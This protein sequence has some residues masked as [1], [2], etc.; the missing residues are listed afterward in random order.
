MRKTVKNQI[1]KKPLFALALIA[2]GIGIAIYTNVGGFKEGNTTMSAKAT[3]KPTATAPAP[4]PATATATA[5]ATA[6]ATANPASKQSD[7]ISSMMDNPDMKKLLGSK[8]IQSLIGGMS[9]G[10]SPTSNSSSTV[11]PNVVAPKM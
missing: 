1:M 8:E 9:G 6:P 3:D 7:L 11:Q 2:F 5:P 10:Q 4:A